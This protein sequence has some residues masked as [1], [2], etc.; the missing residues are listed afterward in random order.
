MLNAE[1]IN[2]PIVQCGSFV[3]N[4][5][6]QLRQA[7][8]DYH[9]RQNVASITARETLRTPTPVKEPPSPQNPQRERLAY[10][11][12]EAAEMLG[13]DYFSVY[14]LV[15]RRKLRVCRALRR[16]ILIPRLELLRLL[17]VE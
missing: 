7:I 3:M 13:I 12:K 17:K 1:P 16:K 14:R 15:Q 5:E 8:R 9:A 6:A 2:E 10:S 4:S 11:L